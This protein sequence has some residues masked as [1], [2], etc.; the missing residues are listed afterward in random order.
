M[1]AVTET[2]WREFGNR[3]RRFI[4]QRV[5][6]PGDAEDLLQESF[7]RIHQNPPAGSEHLSAWVYKLVSNLIHDYYRRRRHWEELEDLPEGERFQVRE[8]EQE[9]AGWLLPMTEKLPEKYG[10]AL[11]LTEFE[12]HT[13]KEAAALLQLS[14]SGTKS[15]VQRARK[16][17]AREVLDCCALYFD[18]K[19]RVVSWRRKQ[20]GSC[21]PSSGSGCAEADRGKHR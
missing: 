6:D 20:T 9:V 8:S 2:V 10:R 14:V 18:E 13:M 7:L 4:A 5:K 21:D 16:M 1:S 11:R 17:L 15:R 12:G 19:G 3:L